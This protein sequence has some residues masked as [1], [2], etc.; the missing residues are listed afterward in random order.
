MKT[1]KYL[2]IIIINLQLIDRLGTWPKYIETVKYNNNLVQDILQPLLLVTYVSKCFVLNYFNNL[3]DMQ[4]AN[5]QYIVY[6][7]PNC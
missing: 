4:S 2:E 7:I 6:D 5:T 3:R 1:L